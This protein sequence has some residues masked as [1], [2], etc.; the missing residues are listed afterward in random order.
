VRAKLATDTF[1]ASRVPL[2]LTWQGQ[3]LENN[4]IFLNFYIELSRYES[5][6]GRDISLDAAIEVTKGL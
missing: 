5:R 3:M 1:F 6:I 4:C 2:C